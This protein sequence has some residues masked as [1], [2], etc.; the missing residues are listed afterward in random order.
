MKSYAAS[1][2]IQ[3]IKGTQSGVHPKSMTGC[4][5]PPEL[6]FENK[7]AKNEAYADLE[8]IRYEGCI[9]DMFTKI[10]TLNDKAIV[11]GAALKKMI[12]ERLPQKIL[13]QMHT[14]DLT[15]KTYKEIIMMVTN[16]GR[17]VEKWDA[18]RNDLVIKRSLNTYEKHIKL[19]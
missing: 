15:G 19:E 16:A 3:W 9:C 8:K 13:E 14:V 12:L 7:D 18:A 5:N 1:W 4:M 6:R 11:S 10:P 17:T 2:H